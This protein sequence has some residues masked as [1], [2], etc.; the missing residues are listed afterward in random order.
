M[1]AG[2]GEPLFARV[3]AA[4]WPT[5]LR[6]V[7][8]LVSESR[9]AYLPAQ[10]RFLAMAVVAAVVVEPDHDTSYVLTLPRRTLAASLTDAEWHRW[11]NAWSSGRHPFSNASSPLSDGSAG[12][13]R[14]RVTQCRV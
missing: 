2:D 7:G 8:R 4:H 6:V 12:E 9:F 3:A 1:N 14:V 13:A 11:R 5:E 10:W